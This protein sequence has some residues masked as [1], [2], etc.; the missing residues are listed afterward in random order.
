[1]S[2]REHNILVIGNGFVGTNL[3]NYYNRIT[4][5]CMTDRN[6]LDLSDKSSIEQYF[7]INNDFTHVIYAA[8]CKDVRYCENNEN[9]AFYIN[10]EVINLLISCLKGEKFI[11][12]STDYVFDGMEGNYSENHSPNPKTVYGRSKLQGEENTL[13]YKN[14]IVVRT[15]GVYGLGSGWMEWITE[16]SKHNKETVC[17][18][19]VRN[20]PTYAENL[21]EMILD[22]INEDFSGVIN[23]SGPDRIDRF[24]LYKYVLSCYNMND[25]ILT[26]GTCNGTLPYDISLDTSKYTSLT[27]KR[28][29]SLEFGLGRL[30]TE[31]K[32]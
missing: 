20:S 24:E 28:P 25:N 7:F 26:Q 1:M 22:V 19:D 30:I 27:G 11:Y 32:R 15:S 23:L 31:S 2:E 12:I 16:Q 3:F 14:S 5:V 29:D 9:E 13:K 21:A 10:A 17:Y 6:I 8:G 18:T 4:N